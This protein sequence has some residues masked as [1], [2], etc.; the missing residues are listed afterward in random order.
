MTILSAC[1]QAAKLMGKG[2]IAVLFASTDP[3]EVE[4]TA[5]ANDIG[6]EI[7]KRHD[8]QKLITLN[9]QVGD[10]ASTAFNLP[11]D[12]DR[13]PIKASVWLSSTSLPMEHVTDLDDWRL[14][15]LLSTSS[16]SGEWI[17]LGG[18]MQIYPAMSASQTASFYYV[19]SSIVTP[20]ASTFTADTDAFKLPERLM[21]LALAWRWRQLK[22][23]DYAEDMETYEIALAQEIA[24][25]K[26]SRM[27]RMGRARMPDGVELAY[28]GVIT[29]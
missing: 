15:R 12:Y 10:G 20:T 4:L 21:S 18:Q 19:S 6:P 7:A 23:L 14:R 24:R 25:D 29:P 9:S 8:W 17:M 22:R 28:P 26:G 13:M 27:L 1:S 2:A 3:F 11:S 16:N 5:L